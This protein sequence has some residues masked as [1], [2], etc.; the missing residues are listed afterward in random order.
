MQDQRNAGDFLEPDA[1][2]RSVLGLLL[3]PSSPCV[4]SVGDVARVLGDEVLA[5]DAVTGLE[6]AG[7]V[8]RHGEV[9]FASYA[10][11]R[12]WALSQAA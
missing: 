8:H 4:W 3:G 1:L 6:M 9:V 5:L 12:C 10:G 7:L 2:E 11:A